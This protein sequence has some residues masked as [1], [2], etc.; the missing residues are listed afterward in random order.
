MQAWLDA[1]LDY[2]PGW[3]DFQMR[4]SERPGCSIAITHKGR[5]VLERAFGSA[6]TVKG[7]K[8][9][10]RH[11]FRAASH[12]KTFTSAA[13]M[14]LREQNH[15]RLDDRVGDYVPG[16]YRDVAECT[17]NQ[18][19]S[20]S[21]GIIRDGTDTGQWQDRRPFLDRQELMHALA[22]PPVLAASMQLKYSNHG[23]GLL[24]LVVEAIAGEPFKDWLS[25]EIITASKL[26]NTQ[27]DGPATTGKPFARGHSGKVLLGHRVVIPADNA[28]NALAPATGIISTA[29]DLARFFASLDPDAKTSV[30]TPASRREMVR[31]QWRDPHST[32]E[33]HYGLGMMIGKV[34]DWE[35]F[36]H[37]G[38]FQGVA[39]RTVTLPK[40]DITISVLTNSIDGPAGAWSDGII[41]I[42]R[43]FSKRGA[44]T[45]ATAGWSGRWWTVW[46]VIDLVAAKDHVAV[47]SPALLNPFSGASKIKIAGQDVGWIDQSSGYGNPGEGARLVR[48]RTGRIREVW[49]AGTKFLP[50]RA[51]R[52]ELKKMYQK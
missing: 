38:G 36:G 31:R 19:L 47:A 50:E 3:L 12:S 49:I 17:I 8:L 40:R 46:G 35:W 14:K 37:S 7:T 33:S 51:A 20:H 1:A 10:S 24:G 45:K 48:G 44:P 28:T 21:A 18:L 11:R 29:G 30:L 26:R 16:L 6:D 25:R 4:Q 34:D 9:T 41:H 52:A 13:I 22:E 32:I 27:P 15:L 39:S 43:G 5:I 42:L 2:I 23:Y